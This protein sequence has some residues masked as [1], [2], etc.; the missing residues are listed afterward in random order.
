MWEKRTSPNTFQEISQVSTSFLYVIL[1]GGIYTGNV[2]DE[3]DTP[4]CHQGL[5]LALPRDRP[6]AQACIPFLEGSS[7]LLIIIPVPSIVQSDGHILHRVTKHD[8]L[9]IKYVELAAINMHV[10]EV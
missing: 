9:K 10:P 6:G 7:Q 8:I 5:E 3:I 4:G 1:G 2:I